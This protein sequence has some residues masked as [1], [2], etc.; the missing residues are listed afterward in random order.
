MKYTISRPTLNISTYLLGIVV[1]VGLVCLYIAARYAFG[2][3]MIPEQATM[4]AMLIEVGT[5]AE[6]IAVVRGKAKW[7]I[8]A[9][10]ISFAVSITYNYIQVQIAGREAGIVSWWQLFTMAVGPLSVLTFTALQ[11][12]TA[13]RDHDEAVAQWEQDYQ[14]WIDKENRRKDRA[15]RRRKVAGKTDWRTLTPDEK[16]AI[17]SLSVH[18]IMEQFPVSERTAYDW[19]NKSQ[20]IAM[21]SHKGE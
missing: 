16:L 7:G 18:Q 4:A 3:V 10:I 11:V 20:Q 13:L 21:K 15:K 5:I 17:S 14:D 6:A 8:L 19:K 12:G 9:L 2:Q 1:V